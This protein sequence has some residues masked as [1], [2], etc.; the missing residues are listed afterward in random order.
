MDYPYIR[1]TDLPNEILMIIFRKLNNLAVLYSLQGV[2][3]RLNRIVHDPI[4]TVHLSFVGWSS[5]NYINQF[6]RDMVLN[7]FCLQILPDIHAKIKS[8]NLE[9]SSVKHILLQ[10]LLH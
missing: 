5:N 3:E 2:S 4:F 7:R 10:L 8:L 1:L 9:P 6:C